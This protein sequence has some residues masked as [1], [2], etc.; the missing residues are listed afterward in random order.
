MADELTPEHIENRAYQ[1]IRCHDGKRRRLWEG[2]A[3]EVR[4][5][6]A[7]EPAVEPSFKGGELVRFTNGAVVRLAPGAPM[8]TRLTDQPYK[9]LRYPDPAK[10]DEPPFLRPPHLSKSAL[11]GIVE[12]WDTARI[13]PPREEWRVQWPDLTRADV[14]LVAES[15]LLEEGVLVSLHMREVRAGVWHLYRWGTKRV[16]PAGDRRMVH[17]VGKIGRRKQQ[18]SK[19]RWEDLQPG[20]GV[21]YPGADMGAL[22]QSVTRWLKVRGL[23]WRVR[24]RYVDKGRVVMVTRVDRAAFVDNDINARFVP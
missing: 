4:R 20:I 7:S 10:A 17:T 8:I 18:V 24:M 2:F 9:V 12:I 19:Y 6:L 5:A 15:I 11:P 13:T 16:H 23:P 14:R 3:G 21:P 22:R 1:W